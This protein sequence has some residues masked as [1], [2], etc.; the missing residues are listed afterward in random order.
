MKVAPQNNSSLQPLPKNVAPD[1]SHNVNSTSQERQEAPQYVVDNS[2]TSETLINTPL[3]E[4]DARGLPI[5]Y[6]WGA[7]FLIVIFLLALLV[8]ALKK[9]Q[10]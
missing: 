2:E 1:I 6:M 9:K 7:G 4:V 3:Q 5:Y 10:E 8:W